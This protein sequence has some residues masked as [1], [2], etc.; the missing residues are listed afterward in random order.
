MVVLDKCT[1]IVDEKRFIEAH[2][3]TIE[4]NKENKYFN[5][6]LERLKKYNEIKRERKEAD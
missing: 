4:R 3:A 6:Y 5:P 2:R 1:V